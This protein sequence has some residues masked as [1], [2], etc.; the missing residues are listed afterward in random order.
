MQEHGGETVKRFVAAA[1]VPVLLVL[2]GCGGGASTGN[3]AAGTPA[4]DTFPSAKASSSAS[5]ESVPYIGEDSMFDLL[6]GLESFSKDELKIEG[7]ETPTET[8]VSVDPE[9]SISPSRCENVA[10]TLTQT[11]VVSVKTPAL[12][13]SGDSA[14]G[15]SFSV[16][17][18]QTSESEWAGFRQQLAKCERFKLESLSPKTI[19]NTPTVDTREFRLS[20]IDVSAPDRVQLKYSEKSNIQYVDANAKCLLVT[21]DCMFDTTRQ[22][23]I[24]FIKKGS[25]VIGLELSHF[26]TSNEGKARLRVPDKNFQ[27]IVTAAEERLN[28]VSARTSQ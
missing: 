21:T 19:N 1:S 24:A 13:T 4:A 3:S 26:A 7:L 2:A 11:N 28:A 9:L 10:T 17:G 14:K 12:W 15:D 23:T 25:N 5:P 22:A 20:N 18:G 6:L 16:T 8:E 27:N